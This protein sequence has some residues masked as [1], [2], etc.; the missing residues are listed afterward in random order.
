MIIYADVVWNW[1]VSAI[2]LIQKCKTVTEKN[3]A[4]RWQIDF[5][6]KV[7]RK[8]ERVSRS[9][10]FTRSL[11]LIRVYWKTL[12]WTRNIIIDKRQQRK[13]KRNNSSLSLRKAFI[14]SMANTR[15]V[16]ALPSN[17]LIIPDCI[18]PYLQLHHLL[19]K[20]FLT[21]KCG[22]RYLIIFLY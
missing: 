19:Q 4:L 18:I 11:S 13:N 12:S 21:I 8:N 2:F 9:Y 22:C 17:L 20:I 14:A 16:L 10:L 5:P 7:N 6:T 15:S 1:I 3:K